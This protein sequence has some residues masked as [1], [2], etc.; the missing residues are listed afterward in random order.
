MAGDLDRLKAA[1]AE[2]AARPVHPAVVAAAD[3]VRAR[4]VGAAV[5]ILFYG[6]C[7]RHGGG[8]APD[9]DGVLGARYPQL[10]IFG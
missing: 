10:P 6:S 1:L 4:H 7:L 5:A 2:E 8:M 9:A 3:A